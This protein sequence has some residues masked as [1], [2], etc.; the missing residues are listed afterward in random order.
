MTE[1][2]DEFKISGQPFSKILEVA[3]QIVAAS[4]KVPGNETP[5]RQGGYLVIRDKHNGTP[6]LIERIGKCPVSNVKRY[7]GL[8]L[9]KSERLSNTRLT[10]GHISS[11]QSRD[12]QN[13]K[14]GGAIIA[15][16]LIVSFS[17]LKELFD[18]AVVLALA[19][20]MDW[21]GFQEVARVTEISGN[22]FVK[23]LYNLSIE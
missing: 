7:H 18:E 13:D 1:K 12:T 23:P 15:G 5:E 2:N 11:Y 8:A 3:S 9:E 16:D 19:L 4:V 6:L 22:R 20:R 17:G 10:G 21:L 14:W